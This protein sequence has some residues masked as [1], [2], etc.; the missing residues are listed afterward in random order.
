MDPTMMG[1]PM[2][3]APMDPAMMGGAPGGQ[4]PMDMAS[5]AALA[6]QLGIGSGAPGGAPAAPASSDELNQ[7]IDAIGFMLM[8]VVETMGIDISG[9]GGE[10]GGQAQQGMAPPQ[11]PPMGDPAQEEVGEDGSGG[12]QS[13]DNVDEDVNNKVL[14]ESVKEGGGEDSYIARQLRKLRR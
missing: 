7:K 12:P 11:G 10:G 13:L 14:S 2:P 4:P 3:P 5:M 9:E 1:A 6:Q 8:K